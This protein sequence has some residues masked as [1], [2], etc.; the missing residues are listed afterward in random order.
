MPGPAQVEDQ[1]LQLPKLLREDGADRETSD[2]LH[3]VTLCGEAGWRDKGGGTLRLPFPRMDVL[4]VSH[5]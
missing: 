5:G 1:L 4:E 3:M 2:C